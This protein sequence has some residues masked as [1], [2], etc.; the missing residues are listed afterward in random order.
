M[1]ADDVWLSTAYERDTVTL[2]VHLPLG[3]DD[4]P[5]YRAC[6]EIFFNYGGRPHWGKVNYLTGE[7]LR[8]R[9]PQ[10]DAWWAARDSLDPDDRFLNDY[11]ASIRTR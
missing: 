1:A 3:E 11:L 5:Y 2:S 8:E 4:A 7:Q 10:W 6:E 9:H